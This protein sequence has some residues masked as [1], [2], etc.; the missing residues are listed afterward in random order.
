MNVLITG[1]A[2]Y[3]G[4]ILVGKLLSAF[5]E[6]NLFRDTPISFDEK[7]H[8][9]DLT[10]LVVYDNLMYKQVC[11]TDYMYV[12]EFQFVH[13]DVRDHKTL[14]PYIQQADVIIPL[15]AIVGFPASERDRRLAT[16]IN[17][18]QIQFIL[19]NTSSQQC[20][21]F[22]TTNSGYGIGESGVY[23]TEETP[24]NPISHYGRTKCAAEQIL[25]DSSRA[26]TLR[27][28]TAFGVS[29]RMRL[30]LLVNN[31]V[32]KA[33]TDGYIVL[34]EKDFK[35]NFIHVRDVALT[36][37]Y[38][39]NKY[40]QFVGQAFN[41][42]LSDANLSK[43]ELTER[44]Q[45]Y[46]PKFVVKYDDFATDPDKRDYIV[47]NAKIEATGWRPY[48]TLDMGIQELVKAYSIIGHNNKQFTNL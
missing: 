48:Y 47:S 4:S 14:L 42:G 8:R 23:C 22:P 11:L 21:I 29:P 7:S 41:V 31:F 45:K 43:L 15:A 27:L 24:L 9:L 33:V 39:I 6:Y 3:V 26:I 16:E 44:I 46:V 20:I 17:F 40:S 37:I 13:G 19:N 36:F 5:T 2:G 10:K 34:F 12:K 38:M 28:A 32:Y 1:G 30:D 35:R 18:E 25:L